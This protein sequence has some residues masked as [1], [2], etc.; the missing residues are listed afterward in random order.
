MTED[1]A[2][3]AWTIVERMRVLG[4]S[5]QDV[6]DRSNLSKVVVRELQHNLVQRRRSPRTLEA[7][8]VAL[9]LHP[10]HLSGIL[11][12]RTV[13]TIHSPE[14]RSYVILDR[15]AALESRLD[16]MTTLLSE[17]DDDLGILGRHLRER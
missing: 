10:R 3:V 4:L 13:E 9:G 12:G 8:S 16:K 5:Q 17:M 15:L 2:A 11:E 1:W 14:D 6:I 7:M